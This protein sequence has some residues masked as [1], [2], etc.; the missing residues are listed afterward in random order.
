MK[1]AED[2]KQTMIR[3]RTVRYSGEKAEGDLH[4]QLGE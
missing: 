3:Q 4:F 2:V 1:V